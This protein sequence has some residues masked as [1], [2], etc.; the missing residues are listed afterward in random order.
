MS[1]TS[2]IQIRNIQRRKLSQCVD[3]ATK[4]IKVLNKFSDIY[5]EQHEVLAQ[6]ARFCSAEVESLQASISNLRSSF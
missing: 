3:N 4:I 1:V 5:N 6:T 2:Q